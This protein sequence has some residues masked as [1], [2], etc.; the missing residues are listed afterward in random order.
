MKVVIHSGDYLKI[1]EAEK[2]IKANF[3]ELH[4]YKTNCLIS[5]NSGNADEVECFFPVFGHWGG[6]QLRISPYCPG[7]K[8]I[9]IEG[10]RNDIEIVLDKLRVPKE[11]FLKFCKESG[12]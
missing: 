3:K 9:T 1:L 5:M 10:T 7:E 11:K 2:K 6:G 8:C 12:L 4:E